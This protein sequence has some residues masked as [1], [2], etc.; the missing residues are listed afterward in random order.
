MVVNEPCPIS[1]TEFTM[2]TMPSRSILSHWLG[3]KTPAVCASAGPMSQ[4]Q[5]ETD[6]Q[7]RA[8]DETAL[9]HG[10]ARERERGEAARPG[11]LHHAPP[12]FA[13]AWSAAARWM[14]ARMRG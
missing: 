2:V 1:G 6:E 7:S 14:A 8:G 13:C 9:E 4:R 10:A 11:G 3:A 5:P 12:F